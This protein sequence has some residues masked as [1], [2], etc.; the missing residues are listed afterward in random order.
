[1]RGIINVLQS[2]LRNRLILTLEGTKK[3]A[4]PRKRR[5]LILISLSVT[6]ALGIFPFIFLRIFAKEWGHAVFNIA[7]FVVFVFNALYVYKTRKEYIARMI[8]ALTLVIG[9]LIGFNLNGRD[10]L[11]WSYPALVALFF[12]VR[13]KVAAIFCLICISW[14][15][16]I[17]YPLME[18]F[19][20][21]TYLFTVSFTCMAVF[22]FA[23]ITQQQHEALTQLSRRDPLTNLRNRRAF[24]ERLDEAIG[25]VRDSQHTSLILFDIDHFK[26]LNDEYGHSVGDD[27]LCKLGRLVSKRLR[28]VDKIYRI[29]GEEFAIV[30]SSTNSEKA[31]RVADDIRTLIE[32][33]KIVDTRQLTISLGVAEYYQNESRDSWFKRC[34]EALYLAKDS[35][36]NNLKLAPLRAVS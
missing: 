12:A 33:A 36:R 9:L 30:L 8:F 34:D 11:M 14:G 22:I 26:S 15:A 2:Y 28:K 20:F 7:L 21:E 3:M 23:N 24:E 18:L 17:L 32:Q 4:N 35:G 27:V 25:S 19:E 1:M 10:E 6:F 29:G 13:A 5:E 16:Y 31:K